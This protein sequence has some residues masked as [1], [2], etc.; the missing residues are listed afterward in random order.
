M[1]LV[2]LA[3]LTSGL[4]NVMIPANAT[5][6]D[7]GYI[8]GHAK[9]GTVVVSTHEQLEKIEKT[10][11]SLPDLQHVVVIDPVESGKASVMTLRDVE[12]RASE[13][14]TSLIEERADAVRIGDL[15]TVMYTS[16]TTGEPKGVQ[17]SHR[18]LVFKRFARA[19]ALPEIGE[20]DVFLCYLPLFHT[21]GRYLEMLGCVFWGARYCFLRDPSVEALI[22]GMRRYRPS[23]FISVPRKWIQLYEAITKRADPL[24]APDEQVRQATLDLTGGRLRWGLSAAGY[25]DPD[26]FRFFHHQGTQLLSG[27]GMSE[28]T[29]GITMTPPFQYK[30]NSLGVALP[31]IDLKLAEDGE[32]LIRGPYVMIGYLDPPDGRPSF[33]EEG[34][35]HSGDLMR[36]DDEGHIRLVD[37]KKEIYKNVKG[38]TIAPQRIENLFREFASVGRAFLVGDH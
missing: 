36:T 15:A 3:C 14:P 26:I 22:D 2:D 29:G 23:V 19:L 7:V 37:R 24:D 35:L 27:F 6:A 28:A 12:S 33:D 4:E 25:L 21:F 9:V 11:T 17:Y 20:Q 1:A 10:R 38:Q 8:L 16:G 30:D 13:I 34:W 5:D 18:N 31:G 32:L